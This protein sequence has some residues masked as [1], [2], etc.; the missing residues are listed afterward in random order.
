MEN[1]SFKMHFNWGQPD[2]WF[3]SLWSIKERDFQKV[4]CISYKFAC[5]NAFPA[6]FNKFTLR[7]FN[8]AIVIFDKLFFLYTIIIHYAS[9]RIQ[10][11][12]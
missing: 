11:S 5:K 8:Q 7:Y 10:I 4:G 2:I 1:L 3:R 6:I 12:R 9:F